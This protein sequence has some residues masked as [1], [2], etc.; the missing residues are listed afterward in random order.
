MSMSK[1]AGTVVIGLGNPLM[2]DDGVGLAMLERLRTY[3]F[4]PP[5]EL[6]DGGTWG[7]NLLPVIEDAGRVLLLDAI[8]VGAAPATVIVLKRD[9]LPRYL[10]TKVSPHQVDLSDVLA[11][12]EL[13]GTLPEHTVAV[14]VQPERVEM[15]TGLTAGVERQMSRAI[16]SALARLHEWGH[17]VHSRHGAARA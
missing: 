2:A 13:R 5:V 10:A 14:G 1:P 12:A 3:E 4:D 7:L 16:G 15:E 6:V 9:Q 17:R 8:N 11:L